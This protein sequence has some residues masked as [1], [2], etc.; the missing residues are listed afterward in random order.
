MGTMKGSDLGSVEQHVLLA[1]FRLRGKGYGVS[2]RDEI[3]ARAERDYSL[4]SIYAALERLEGKGY[5]TSEEGEPTAERGGRRKLYF[6]ITAP[7]KRVL[8][9]ALNTT[10]KLREGID[11]GGVPA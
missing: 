3:A 8:Q 1:V 7:G 10:D 4:G 6:D 5:L 11:L 2:I 9:D